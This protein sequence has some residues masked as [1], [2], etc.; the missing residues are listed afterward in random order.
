MKP[1]NLLPVLMLPHIL[2]SVVRGQQENQNSRNLTSRSSKPTHT[3]FGPSKG[4]TFSLLPRIPEAKGGGSSSGAG[5]GSGAGKSG[6]YGKGSAS[7]GAGSRPSKLFGA[8][9]CGLW[10]SAWGNCRDRT[11]TEKAVTMINALHVDS[12]ERIVSDLNLPFSANS[13]DIAE[14]KDISQIAQNEIIYQIKKILLSGIDSV[15]HSNYASNLGSS[16]IQQAIK[17]IC[18][19]DYAAEFRSAVYDGNF[20]TAIE[21]LNDISNLDSNTKNA[22]QELLQ[23]L[24]TSGVFFETLGDIAAEDTVRDFENTCNKES[25]NKANKIKV[26]LPLITLAIISALLMNF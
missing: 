25:S 7:K 3:D 14:I 24:N 9:A 4:I 21:I 1:S 5:K 2:V 12:L 22:L 17:N 10:V 20:S 11:M 23:I 16:L 26:K 15:C 8:S 13:S 18:T 19:S 6:S